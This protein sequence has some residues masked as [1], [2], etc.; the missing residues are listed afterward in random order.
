MLRDDTPA[1]VEWA[2]RAIALA[3][4]LCMPELRIAALVEKGSALTGEASQAETG[5]AILREVADEGEKTGEW[6]PAARALNNLIGT[7]SSLSLDEQRDVLERMRAAAERAGFDALAV[8]AYFQGRANLAL[9]DGD[10]AAA[11]AAIE[12]GRRRDQGTLRTSRGTDYHGV[13]RAGLALEAGDLELAGSITERLVAEPGAIYQ[14][15][16]PGLVFHVA[17]RRGDL[18]GAEEALRLV[19]E[20]AQSRKLWGDFVHDLVAAGLAAGFAEAALRPLTRHLSDAPEGWRSLV[21]GQLA[22][23]RRDVEGALAGYQRAVDAADLPPAPRGTAHAGAA[24]CLLALRRRDEAVD[25][26][27]RAGELLARWGGWRVAELA[28]GRERAGLG[29]V[30]STVD[31]GL[32]PRELEVAHLLAA[33]LTN[34]ELA[35]RLFISPRTAAVHVSN[36]LG[37]LGVSSRTQV[38]GRLHR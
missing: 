38:A 36:I 4:E 27:G 30:R 37:K 25:H 18:A 24:R 33:G 8:A 32:T 29:P 6:L 11:T 3:D 12:D 28:A 15:S 19:L 20:V 35:R 10:L 34:A 7:P 26:L 22:E 31:N 9:A 13:F 17:C 14:L 2:D 23:A 16:V 21:L 5:I 1:A